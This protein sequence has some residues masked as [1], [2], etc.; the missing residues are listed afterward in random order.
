MQDVLDRDSPAALV[1]N[2]DSDGEDSSDEDSSEDE[3]D[4]AP[5]RVNTN[6]AKALE[7][8]ELFESYKLKKY[9]P[10]IDT[11]SDKSSVLSG[12]IDGKTRRIWVGPVLK[13]GRNLPSGRNLAD[14]IDNRGRIDLVKFF[15]D[16]K[17]IFPTLWIVVQRES[18]RR[19]VEVGCERFFSISGYVSSARRTRLG[20]RTYER[21]A[22]L[23]IILKK[24]YIDKEWVAKE[25]LR[26]C[27]EG[28]W[29]SK[30][31]EEAVK[32]WN[33]ERLIDTELVGGSKPEPLTVDDLLREGGVPSADGDEGEV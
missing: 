16:H 9:L 12:T 26:R 10:K 17:K 30:L 23:A 31:T 8:L 25:Y 11:D 22:L 13:K 33:L 6:F 27:K 3:E 28:L 5:A 7:E 14:Y 4:I 24:V 1:I 20:V 21:I 19:V 2:S 15:E 18:S 32:C 29:D